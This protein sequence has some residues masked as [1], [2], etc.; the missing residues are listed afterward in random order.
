VPSIVPVIVG[1]VTAQHKGVLANAL[2]AL[3]L[4]HEY[5]INLF[6]DATANVDED[7]LLTSARDL[8]GRVYSRSSVE[9]ISG[10][11]NDGLRDYVDQTQVN[12]ARMQ[13]LYGAGA[14]HGVY[15]QRFLRQKALKGSGGFF[16]LV[17][18]VVEDRC[19]NETLALVNGARGAYIP[20][21][22]NVV[23]IAQPTSIDYYQ[24]IRGNWSSIV[25]LIVSSSEEFKACEAKQGLA[26]VILSGGA[27]N[28][29][30]PLP[31]S[32]YGNAGAM[33]CVNGEAFLYQ[34]LK[35]VYHYYDP[36]LKGMFVVDDSCIKAIANNPQFDSDFTMVGSNYNT[37]DPRL[38]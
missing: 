9:Y 29:T 5:P 17:V 16:D 35:Q 13:G 15:K 36:H 11:D 14:W 37:F 18:I 3:E 12:Y 1:A 21:N 4:N 20:R 27:A 32:G 22:A 34:I 25:N 33:A 28:P 30:A 7:T 31:F 19:Y 6:E 23:V 38:D 24:R 8:F 26:M 2:Q 10:F